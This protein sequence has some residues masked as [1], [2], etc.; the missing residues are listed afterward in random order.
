V[1]AGAR[2][3]KFSVM[4]LNELKIVANPISSFITGIA[5]VIVLKVGKQLNPLAFPDNFAIGFL[6]ALVAMCFFLF[7]VRDENYVLKL[8]YGFDDITPSV[9][10]RVFSFLGGAACAV[11]IA[12]LV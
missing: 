11:L 12:E 3:V 2:A 8:W 10:L 7:V 4:F 1:K 9:L 6:A 5:S